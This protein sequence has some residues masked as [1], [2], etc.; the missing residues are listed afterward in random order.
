MNTTHNYE[1]SNLVAYHQH[2]KFS[3]PIRQCIAIMTGSGVAS[4]EITSTISI[5]SPNLT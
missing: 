1:S 4:K 3:F 2:R 5:K